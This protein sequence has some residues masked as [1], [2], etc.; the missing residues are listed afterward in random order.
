[1]ALINKS[2]DM[3]PFN[4]SEK[5][6]KQNPFL[7]PLIWGASFFLTRQ[8]GLK[9][10]KVNMKNVKSPFLV[11]ATH[12]GFS[13]YYI[14]PISVF[15]KRAM[16]VSDMEGF[17]AFGKSL[18]RGIGCI[19]KRRY[20]SDLSVITNIKY[21]LKKGQSVFIYP[22]SRHSNIGITA[23]I[24]A[25]MGRL[26][27]ILKVPLVILS[28]HGSYLANPFWNEEKTR[29]VPMV[30]KME[31]IYTAEQ[32]AA[33]SAEEIQK[34]IEKELQ[35]NEYDYQH[36]KGFLINDSD[37][38]EG[39][40]RALYQCKC[41]KK[42]YFM[43][44]K[45]TKLICKSCGTVWE[46]TPD[47]WLVNETENPNEKISPPDWYLFE[48][49]EAEKEATES[50]EKEFSVDVQALPNEKGFVDLG[51]GKLVFNQNE[52]VLDYSDANGKK[53]RLVFPHKIRESLQTEYNYRKKG[54]AI[55]LSTKDCCYYLYSKDSS[56]EPTELQF[57]SE[58]LFLR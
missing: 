24:P 36:E 25:N 34:R 35:Y 44:T 52:F 40:E 14:G 4:M 12:Q 39:L 37:R 30:A 26:A 54:R 56:F 15:P 10:Q 51:K 43:K 33:L 38:A 11:L 53:C 3:T 18:Y 55:V 22:E 9:I 27:K 47:G 16:Y 31:C 28:V 49:T 41:C 21:A 48:K 32:I 7:L 1:M 45:G 57:K 29:K 42:K 8:F 5:P 2:K 19:G 13:D 23:Y 50:F 17:A 20:V 6:V 46:F 58:Y